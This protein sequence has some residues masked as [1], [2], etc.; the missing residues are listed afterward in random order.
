[1][2][3]RRVPPTRTSIF[4]TGIVAPSGP[5]QVLK[6]S[7]SVHIC[8]TRANGAS[9]MRSITTA[10]AELLSVIALTCPS[11]W[12]ELVE[13]VVHLV[14]AGLPDGPVAFSPGRDLLERCRVQGARPVLGSLAPHDQ[15]GPFQHLD[16]LRDG[17]KRHLERLG[18]LVDGR[19]AFGEAGEDR[20]PSRA[21]QGGKG[22]A[23]PV[24][25]DHRRH[26][27]YFPK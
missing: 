9:T 2:H 23:E 16:V 11:S 19:P 6:C 25:V 10:S 21:G 24:L 22:L 1:M 8:Q 27:L 20:P 17:R 26:G 4:A 14:E 7:G 15:P 18:E 5:Y 12:P 3:T 13:V